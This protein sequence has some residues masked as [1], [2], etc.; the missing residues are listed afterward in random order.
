MSEDGGKTYRHLVQ[1]SKLHGDVHELYIHPDNSNVI[2]NGNDGC[3]GISRDRGK[4]WRFVENLPFAQ[5]YHI[6]VDM[7]KP[8]NVYGGLQDNGSW[9]GPSR[10]LTSRNGIL[11]LY[12]AR[13]GGGDGF[14]VLPDAGNPARFGYAMSQGGNIYH[15]DLVTGERKNIKPAHPDGL[16]L[17]FNW[18][19][20]IAQDPFDNGT[21]YLG[22][23]FVHK[24]TDRGDSWEIISPDLTTDDP[25]KQNQIESGGLSYDATGAAINTT[26]VSNEPSPARAG[27]VWL[28]TVYVTLCVAWGATAP[29]TARPETA[30]QRRL[31]SVRERARPFRTAP[32]RQSSSPRWRR[33]CP[34]PPPV[35]RVL[36]DC[37][38]VGVRRF[39]HWEG[40]AA[41]RV[42]VELL[43]WAISFPNTFLGKGKLMA[44][45]VLRLL[46]VGALFLG[47]ASSSHAA[48]FTPLGDLAG[49]DFHSGAFDVS[50]DGS[51]VVGYSSSASGDEAFVWDATNGMQG[52]GTWPGAAS[53]ATP[54]P[55][56][57][58]VR[59]WWVSASRPRAARRSSG[60]RRTGCRSSMSCLRPW[61]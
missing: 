7:E 11:N 17:R 52:L 19:A 55:S 29:W 10:V 5:F 8:Y 43:E 53:P 34:N 45:L 12:W 41:L 54:P 6:A 42:V 25:E 47:S 40:G 38:T 44:G 22:S 26:T 2:I 60:M 28:G 48:S 30:A 32:P 15:F 33:R 23:Q 4:T 31:A 1:S 21:I 27:W 61:A 58:M 20:A 46:I 51:T 18:N 37:G 49:G 24:S 14:A 16:F 39:A 50:G 13:L 56:R 57:A 3:I 36:I 9:R 35:P 59:P